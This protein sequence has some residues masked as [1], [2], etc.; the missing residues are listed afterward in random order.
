M[1]SPGQQQ[2]GGGFGLDL[3]PEQANSPGHE[4]IQVRGEICSAPKIL[5]LR[6]HKL[7]CCVTMEKG[8]SPSPN[9]SPGKESIKLL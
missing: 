3:H 6:G 2:Q 8:T 9:P 4:L 1:G 5:L 7:L